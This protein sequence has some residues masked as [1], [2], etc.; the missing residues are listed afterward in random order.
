MMFTVF[1]ATYNRAYCLEQLYNSLKRQTVKNFDWLIIDDD[2]EDNTE[3]IVRK[4]I[5]E[6]EIKITYIK[7][8]INGGLQRAI[9][10]AYDIAEGEYCLKVDSDDYLLDDA[11]EN[12]TKWTKEIK[13]LT[14]CLGVAGLYLKPDGSILREEQKHGKRKDSFFSLPV[15][16][17]DVKFYER[18]QYNL[19]V[20]TLETYKVNIRKNYKIPVWKNEKDGPERVAF[21]DMAEDGYFIRWYKKPIAVVNYQENGMTLNQEKYRLKNPMSQAICFN[22]YSNYSFVPW[23]RKIYYASEYIY[24]L[25]KGKNFKYLFKAQNVLAT[26]LGL[27][28]G[29]AKI[30]KRRKEKMNV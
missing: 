18:E 17:V 12:L 25:Y 20:D 5:K 4:W 27:P 21:C 3:I 19:C 6:K 1:T 2:S 26:I 8:E 30:L 7:N 28:I 22:N 13:S 14:K 11:I 23:K 29:I 24:Y 16:Y 10:K 15:E 9:N